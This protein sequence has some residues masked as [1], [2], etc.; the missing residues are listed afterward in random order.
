MSSK[1]E[2]LVE[3]IF[4]MRD[5]PAARAEDAARKPLPVVKKPKNDKKD[6]ARW[7][8][9]NKAKG[10]N[11]PYKPTLEQSRENLKSVVEGI[12]KARNKVLKNNHDKD[13]GMKAYMRSPN[14]DVTQTPRVKNAV[15][16]NRK[17]GDGGGAAFRAAGREKRQEQIRIVLEGFVKARNKEL[18]GRHEKKLGVQS[19]A[20][21]NNPRARVAKTKANAHQK[22]DPRGSVAGAAMLKADGRA[23]RQES[24]KNAIKKTFLREEEDDSTKA[25]FTQGL[26]KHMGKTTKGSIEKS[27]GDTG[28]YDKI[29]KGKDARKAVNMA[30]VHYQ[31]DTKTGGDSKRRD[32]KAGPKG[33]S[34]KNTFEK[35]GKRQAQADKFSKGTKTAGMSKDAINQS[36]VEGQYVKKDGQSI[37]SKRWSALKG[38]MANRKFNR[39]MKGIPDGN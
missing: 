16:K 4:E 8:A 14:I 39:S 15:K 19:N 21:V 22:Q 32:L 2:S 36:G 10:V 17:I 28:A 20:T 26:M 33:H 34:A 12:V 25:A 18:K 30:P 24:F 11:R 23:S 7:E 9:M 38:A 27:G 35:K 13:A 37:P 1:I 6:R 31:P 5:E 3:N 29:K